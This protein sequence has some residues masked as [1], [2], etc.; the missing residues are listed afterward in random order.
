[1]ENSKFCSVSS[2]QDHFAYKDDRHEL[3][4]WIF[5][6]KKSLSCVFVDFS[7]LYESQSQH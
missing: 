6:G 4:D 5:I 7:V 1:M 2:F 3:K